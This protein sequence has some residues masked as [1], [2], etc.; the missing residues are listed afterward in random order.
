MFFIH[1]SDNGR[2]G[3]FHVLTIVNSTAVNIEVHISFQ[4]I[5][6]FFFIYSQE[7]MEGSYNNSSF[8]MNLYTLLPSVCTNLHS[9]QYCRQF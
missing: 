6:L 8:L 4:I 3:C 7:G 9:H 1:S 2:L 5:V